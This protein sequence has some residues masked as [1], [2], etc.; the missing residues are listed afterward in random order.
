VEK[1]TD[2]QLHKQIARG[3]NVRDLAQHPGF[4]LIMDILKRQADEALDK[5]KIE[6]DMEKIKELQNIIWRHDEFAIQMYAYIEMG[7]DAL[8]ELAEKEN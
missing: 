4:T 7:M 8:R 3:N 5:L 1:V 6:R 2:E